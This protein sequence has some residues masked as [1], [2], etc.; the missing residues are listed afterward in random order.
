MSR[1]PQFGQTFVEGRRQALHA[2]EVLLAVHA[3]VLIVG[4][5]VVA[6]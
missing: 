1:G 2:V 5:S 6:R 3:A 4:L